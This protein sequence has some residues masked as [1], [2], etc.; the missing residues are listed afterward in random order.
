MAPAAHPV[1]EVQSGDLKAPTCAHPPAS[2]VILRGREGVAAVRAELFRHAARYAAVRSK[3]EF[4]EAIAEAGVRTDRPWGGDVVSLLAYTS[5]DG[6]GDGTAPRGSDGG[7]LSL[8][9]QATAIAVQCAVAAYG[10]ARPGLEA[11]LRRSSNHKARLIA[12]LPRAAD[13]T[14][15]PP[16]DANSDWLPRHTD[17]AAVTMLLKPECPGDASACGLYLD[18]PTARGAPT[19]AD[20]LLTGDS[21]V[22]LQVGDAF[23]A[24]PGP[25]GQPLDVAPVL[26]SVHHVRRS[27]RR[28]RYQLAVFLCPAWRT[29]LYRPCPPALR[30]VDAVATA[31][32]LP[33]LDMRLPATGNSVPF[34]KFSRAT[35]SA[36]WKRADG[37]GGGTGARRRR[38]ER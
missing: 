6:H 7:V 36:Y 13:A 9:H 1:V 21:D 17:Y 19:H 2:A 11:A 4:L 28:E 35:T 12:Y 30:A 25:D 18:P 23:N 38:R 22:L 31:H 16:P 27:T 5:G 14:A 20:A 8:L 3:G 37:G 33:T 10:A 15:P 32:G 24:L 34:E 26:P 29:P